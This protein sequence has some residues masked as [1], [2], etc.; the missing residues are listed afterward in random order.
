[1]SEGSV[2][3]RHNLAISSG[4][5]FVDNKKVMTFCKTSRNKNS[6]F[7]EL[8]AINKSLS[9]AYGY[10]AQKNMFNGNFVI[11]LYTDSLTSITSIQN[12][13]YETDNEKRNQLINEIKDTINKFND[14]VVFYHIKSHIS[15]SN[16]KKAYFMFCKENDIDISFSE[17]QFL[18]QQNKKCDKMISQKFIKIIKEKYLSQSN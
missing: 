1:M 13:N 6:D 7:A 3:N 16:L 10:C 15:L 17:F 5:M 18:Y 8:F 14:K 2:Y 12:E 9:R 11:N 4:I